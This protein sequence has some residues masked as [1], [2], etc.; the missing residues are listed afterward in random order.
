VVLEKVSSGATAISATP[1]PHDKCGRCWHWRE[2]VGSDA[3]HPELCGR[4]VSNLH[5][6]GEAREFA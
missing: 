1:S 3:A 4:C 2:D 5:G 6:A